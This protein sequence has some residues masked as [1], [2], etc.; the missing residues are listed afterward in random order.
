LELLSSAIAAFLLSPSLHLFLSLSMQRQQRL[1][2]AGRA[3]GPRPAAG[4]PAAPRRRAALAT[5]RAALVEPGATVLVAGATGGVGQLVTAKLVERGY[6]VRA[7]VRDRAKA[8]RTLGEHP[9]LELVV[10]DARDA[11]PRPRLRGRRRRGVRHRC[12]STRARNARGAELTRCMRWRLAAEEEGTA[13][14]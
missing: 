7:M 9:L 5:P 1:S 11:Q 13:R 4:R 3:A 8:A 2:A 10:A 12:A 6:R 14:S